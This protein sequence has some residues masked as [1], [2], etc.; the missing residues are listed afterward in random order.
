VKKLK[1]KVI[2]KRLDAGP[3]GWMAEA[4]DHRFIGVREYGPTKEAV[5]AA[6]ITHLLDERRISRL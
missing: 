2:F 5:K 6:I 1:V 3:F 4:D